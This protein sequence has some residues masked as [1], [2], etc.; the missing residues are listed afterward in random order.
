MPDST[1]RTIDALVAK[2]SAAG[3]AV[4]SEVRRALQR[5]ARQSLTPVEYLER[6]RRVILRHQPVLAEALGDALLASWLTG[7]RRAAA[8]LPNRPP[9]V[10]PILP[11]P[12]QPPFTQAT[13][14]DGSE[15][16]VRYPVI[17][18]AARSLQA[19]QVMVREEF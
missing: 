15:P 12:E 14:A 16:L 7:A 9:L 11:P 17:E 1:L 5:L 13:A 10:Q 19:K 18:A 3:I 8:P 6:A 2:S 4:S